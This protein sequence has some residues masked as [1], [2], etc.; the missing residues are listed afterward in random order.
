MK[1]IL[2]H[3]NR[4]QLLIPALFRWFIISVINFLFFICLLTASSLLNIGI[5]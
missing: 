4:K 1:A 2:V 5:G 3:Y